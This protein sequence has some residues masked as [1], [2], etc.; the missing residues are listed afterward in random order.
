MRSSNGTIDIELKKRCVEAFREGMLK[1]DIYDTIFAPERDT[2]TYRTFARELARWNKKDW[3]DQPTLVGGTY[4]GFQAYNAT[5]QVGPDGDIRQAWIRQNIDGNRWEELL[6]TIK[7]NAE[8]KMI[9][10]DDIPSEPAMLEIP[11]F[12]M[13]FPQ[14]AHIDTLQKLLP[15]IKSKKW[16]SI[17]LVVGQDLFHNNDLRGH[18]AS[19]TPIEKVDMA[20]AWNLARNFWCQV[21]EESLYSSDHVNL[22]YSM[23]NHDEA[24]AWAFVEMLKERYPQINVDDDLEQRKTIWWNKCFIGLTHGFLQKT[25]VNDLRSQFTIEF[26]QEFANAIVR[27]IHCGHLHHEA[28]ADIYGVMVRRLGRSGID[29]Q[30]TRDNGYIGAHKRFMVFEWNP[31]A[32]KA[33]YYL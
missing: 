19:G 29:D 3:P 5:V 13:H 22:I 21:I 12:D 14:N 16:G 2:F 27:E 30:W 23:G 26:P 4:P 15:I 7:E 6:E 25:R 17:Y 11:L 24:I 20:Q 10:V 32:L 18:T 8:P 28:E 1:R 31:G 9:D 33:I